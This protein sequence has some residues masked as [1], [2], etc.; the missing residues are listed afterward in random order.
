MFAPR[1]R[2]SL[3]FTPGISFTAAGLVP[4]TQ[5]RRRDVRGVAVTETGEKKKHVEEALERV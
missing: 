1:S 3:L 5:P 4:F 2:Q